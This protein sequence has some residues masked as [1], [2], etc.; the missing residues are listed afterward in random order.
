MLSISGVAAIQLVAAVIG[1]AILLGGAVATLFFFSKRNTQ[2]F[3]RQENVDI[4]S[5]LATVEES[6]KACQKR[7]NKAEAT[8]ATLTEV[9]SGHN[10]VV[11]LRGIV[12]EHHHSVMARLD[13]LAT[14]VGP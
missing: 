12:D 8:I 2:D 7:L 5:R 4:R 1:T 13:E 6:E 9:F 3:V 11:E 10:A 14:S